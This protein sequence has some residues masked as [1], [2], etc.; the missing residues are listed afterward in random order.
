[1]DW[2][3]VLFGGHV[4]WLDGQYQTMTYVYTQYSSKYMMILCHVQH[5]MLHPRSQFGGWKN[6]L[7]WILDGFGGCPVR[8][9]CRVIRWSLSSDETRQST[10][11]IEICDDF[12]SCATFNVTSQISV[13]RVKKYSNLNSRW[14]GRKSCSG[15]M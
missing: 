3:E 8:G 5:S 10:V 14:V 6:T 7:T 9:S 12:M 4:D 15:V 13:W 11:F 1:M 2:E